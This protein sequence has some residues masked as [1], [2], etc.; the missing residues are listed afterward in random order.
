[1]PRPFLRWIGALARGLDFW[2]EPPQEALEFGRKAQQG[3]MQDA[4]LMHG[5][6]AD[7]GFVAY[8]LKYALKLPCKLAPQGHCFRDRC[9]SSTPSE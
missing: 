6:T 4:C 3:T 1:M 9:W 8:A 7:G 2:A 5:H